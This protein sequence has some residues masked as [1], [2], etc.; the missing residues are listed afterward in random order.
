MSPIFICVRKGNGYKLTMSRQCCEIR[1]NRGLTVAYKIN[2]AASA[3]RHLRAA[4]ELYQIGA[5]GAQPGSKAVAGYLFGLA[6]ELA[7]KEMMR[8]SGIRPRPATDRQNDPFYAH[9]PSLKARLKEII[10]DRRA[11][12]LR[13]IA[14]DDS[15]FQH[16]N[17]NMRYAPTTDIRQPWIDKWRQSAENLVNKMDV[18]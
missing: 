6:G 13:P 3:R 15:L 14:E 17:T 5:A 10:N 11:Q 18:L 12:E 9:F 4:Q 2:L 7:V 8:A 1:P 16:W